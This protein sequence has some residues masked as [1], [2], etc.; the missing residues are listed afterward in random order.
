MK[1]FGFLFGLILLTLPLLAYA[2]SLSELDKQL[3][4]ANLEKAKAIASGQQPQSSF[5]AVDCL[6]WQ[7]EKAVSGDGIKCVD[8]PDL[9]S[10]SGET[11][12]YIVIGVIIVIIVI[13]IIAK[14][15]R[16]PKAYKDLPRQD[17]SSE[18]EQ[19]TLKKQD[20]KCNDC[21]KPIGVVKGRMVFYEYDHID[22]NNNNND[23]NNCQALCKNCHQMKTERERNMH[24]ND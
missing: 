1:L 12:S 15:S 6:P 11:G 13:A 5:Q 8:N 19:Q 18:V 7:I 24:R 22:G 9:Q 23:P 17:F 3:D 16:S 4:E 21:K 10:L 14:A 2:Q 20:S